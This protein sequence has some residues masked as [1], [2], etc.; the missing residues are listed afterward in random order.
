MCASQ[1]FIDVFTFNFIAA[2]YELQNGNVLR[3]F[4]RPLGI[5]G[6]WVAYVLVAC[7]IFAFA[8]VSSG[9]MIARGVTPQICSPGERTLVSGIIVNQ[10][11]IRW[12][13]MLVDYLN[14]GAKAI[15]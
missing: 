9:C 3:T 12:V 10:E 1:Q 4:S 14:V 7:V 2:W 11:N 6:P 8:S 5:E 13:S 15:T